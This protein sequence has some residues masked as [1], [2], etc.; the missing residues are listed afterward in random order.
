[1]IH[2]PNAPL[3]QIKGWESAEGM[4]NTKADKKGKKHCNSPASRQLHIAYHG[5]DHY[6]SVRRLEDTSHIPANIVI[7]IESDLSEAR[8]Q[9]SSLGS[10]SE[11]FDSCNIHE[12]NDNQVSFMTCFNCFGY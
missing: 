12:M 2:Q 8:C 9:S 5:G 7:D 6:D 4:K 11:E 10:R 1:M 3:W